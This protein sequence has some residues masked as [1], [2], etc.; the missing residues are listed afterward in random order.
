MET[1]A[2]VCDDEIYTR[3][4]R[5]GSFRFAGAES[6]GEAIAHELSVMAAHGEVRIVCHPPKRSW[7]RIPPD[8]NQPNQ[9]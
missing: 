5:R 9:E 6:A 1:S 3:I 2:A 4:V 8:H 7:Q